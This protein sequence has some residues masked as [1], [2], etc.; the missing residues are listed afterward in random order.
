MSSLLESEIM[1]LKTTIILM[2]I[3]TA[4]G[5]Q[6][7]AQ[8]YDTNN[9]VVEVFAGSGTS[10]L[11][12]AQGTLAMF[13]GPEYVVADTSS[14][15]YVCD[16]GNG[17]IRKITPD[18][19][20]STFASLLPPPPYHSF[21][22]SGLA[23]DGNNTIWMPFSGYGSPGIYEIASNGSATSLTYSGINQNS[24]IC[25]DFGN[26]IYYTAGNQVFRISSQGVLALFAGNTSSGSSDGNGINALFSS[27]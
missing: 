8:T 17:L 4:L 20:V 3:A 1:K 13:S 23:I 24:G 7:G 19:T 5:W 6:A 10:G 14:N 22:Y 2:A 25:T 15:L 9:D 11:L 27:P 21:Y 26:N 18:G 12:N 16:S